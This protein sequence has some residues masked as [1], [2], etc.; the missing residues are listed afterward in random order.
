ME[1]R[2]PEDIEAAYKVIYN[3]KDEI[4]KIEKQITCAKNKFEEDELKNKI[5]T[6]VYKVLNNDGSNAYAEIDIL[7]RRYQ[8]VL[9]RGGYY[10]WYKKQISIQTWEMDGS[11][12]TKVKR[13]LDCDTISA[14]Y[15][16]NLVEHIILSIVLKRISMLKKNVDERK[17]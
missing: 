13:M 9:S 2:T 7:H 11:N 15:G 8:I 4:K 5:H 10:G 16:I 3:L 6:A 17:D 12:P 1:I 14:D